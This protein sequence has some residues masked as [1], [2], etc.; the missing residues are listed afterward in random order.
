MKCEVLE[1]LSRLY[2]SE[3]VR[4]KLIPDILVAKEYIKKIYY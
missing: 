3:F 2:L 1:T 4:Q